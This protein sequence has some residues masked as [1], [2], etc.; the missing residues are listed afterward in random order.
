MLDRANSD[1]TFMKRIVT[2]SGWLWHICLASN[3]NHSFTNL[4]S[5]LSFTASAMSISF[6][7]LHIL[8][9][10][11]VTVLKIRFVKWP[12]YHRG[13]LRIFRVLSSHIKIINSRI[14]LFKYVSFWNHFC[15][16]FQIWKLCCNQIDSQ[17][18]HRYELRKKICHVILVQ[19][20]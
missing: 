10:Q 4:L 3:V 6:F 15:T 5:I 20:I 13:G 8:G 16:Y 12:N 1:P 9:L 11:N 2:T 18:T 17:S 7:L 19:V 14:L